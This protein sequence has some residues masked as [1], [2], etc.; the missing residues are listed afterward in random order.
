MQ[1]ISKNNSHHDVLKK[2]KREAVKHKP[3]RAHAIKQKTQ[4]VR[5]TVVHVLTARGKR[6]TGREKNRGNYK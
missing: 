1:T 4:T 2:K 6:E 5:D 3:A